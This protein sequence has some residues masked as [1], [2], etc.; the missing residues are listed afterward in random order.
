MRKIALL[1]LTAVLST[2]TA[3]SGSQTTNLELKVSN[4]CIAA[5]GGFERGSQDLNVGNT[6]TV[7]LGTINALTNVSVNDVVVLAMDCNYKTNIEPK[8]PDFV[9]LTNEKGDTFNINN[10]AWSLSNPLSMQF[11]EDGSFSPDWGY[12]LYELHRYVADFKLG[13]SGNGYQTSWSIPGGSYTG[14]LTVDFTYNE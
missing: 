10:A 7:N 4:V 12:G 6:K 1:A 9:T 14:T 2:A 8:F 11:R 5:Y 3:A 13:G